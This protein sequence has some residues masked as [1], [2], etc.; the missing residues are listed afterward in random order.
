VLAPRTLSMRM[1]SPWHDTNYLSMSGMLIDRRTYQFLGTRTYR[2]RSYL[3]YDRMTRNFF[4][5]LA[6]LAKQQTCWLAPDSSSYVFPNRCIPA[7]DRQPCVPSLRVS[8]SLV[9]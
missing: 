2:D 8:T 6:S 9:S 5:Y 4:S 1:R 7:V 3:Y